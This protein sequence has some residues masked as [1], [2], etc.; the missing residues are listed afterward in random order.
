MANLKCDRIQSVKNTQKSQ[1]RCAW[2]LLGFVCPEQVVLRAPSPTDGRC[3][4]VC[5]RLRFEDVNLPLLRKRE[6]QSV[7][8]L[9]VSRRSGSLWDLQHNIIRAETRAGNYRRM[10]WTTSTSW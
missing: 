1:K 4:T 9:V 10:V 6:V 3:Y 2:W 8:L 7:G 5:K